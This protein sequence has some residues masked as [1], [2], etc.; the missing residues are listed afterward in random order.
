MHETNEIRKGRLGTPDLDR[1]ERL[2]ARMT[3]RQDALH[4]AKHPH[5]HQAPRVASVLGQ[6]ECP[7]DCPILAE[8]H[9]LAKFLIELGQIRRRILEDIAQGRKDGARRSSITRK[10]YLAAKAAAQGNNKELR[11]LLGV[12]RSTLDAWLRQ[13]PDL[14]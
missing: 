13:H 14:K 9:D 7:R 11:H 5:A 4:D 8:Q 1:V 10:K 12:T 3:A 6:Q 2:I